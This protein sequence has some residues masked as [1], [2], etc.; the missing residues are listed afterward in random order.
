MPIDQPMKK[1]VLFDIDGTLI[2]CGTTPRRSITQAM[3]E[4]FGTRGQA[5]SYPFSGKTDSQI[6]YDV[7]TMSGL[8]PEDVES[9]I[10]AALKRYTELLNANLA[11]NEIKI[12]DGVIELLNALTDKPEVFMGLLTGNVM[13]GAKIKLSC[14]GL[15]HYFFNGAPVIG[16]FGS[17][18]R[19][20]H[21]L[22]S[23]AVQRASAIT[24]HA[25]TDKSIV[26]IGDSPYDILCGKH[27]N[28]KSIAVTTGW[29]SL[30]DLLIHQPDHALSGFSD[31]EKTIQCI[32]H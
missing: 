22:A 2:T 25:F 8:K 15:D 14:A 4:I 10:P 29:H 12:L 31:I 1:L 26:I 11:A 23:L 13:E 27:L 3:E 19:H 6:I 16:A 9:K 17:D 7:M 30:E 32:V 28:V 24:G 20:R 5:D 18:S 21:E